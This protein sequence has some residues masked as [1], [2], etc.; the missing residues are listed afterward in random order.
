MIDNSKNL[1]SEIEVTVETAKELGLT[2]N[3][4]NMLCKNIG[5]T[6]TYTEL[7]VYSVMWSEH[8]SYKNS[9]KLLKTL[10][11]SGGK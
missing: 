2:E 9:I 6:P 7:G 11:R 5:R 8:C 10:P 3:E 1:Y 4:Y